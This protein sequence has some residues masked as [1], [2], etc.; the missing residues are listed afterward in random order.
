MS[1]ESDPYPERAWG[2]SIV[3]R[4]AERKT[5][6]PD[7]TDNFDLAIER[8]MRGTI[9][10]D[11]TLDDLPLFK[12]ALR[13]QERVR[14]APQRH[15][16]TSLKRPELQPM[17]TAITKDNGDIDEAAE[18]AYVA[19]IRDETIAVVQRSGPHG[20]AR[21][22]R[23]RRCPQRVEGRRLS[24]QQLKIID[25]RCFVPQ[26]RPRLFI[27][28][29][30]EDLG[31]DPE[32]LFEQALQ[33]LP[34]RNIDP[35]DVLDLDGSRIGEYPPAEVQRLLAMVSPHQRAKLDAALATGRLV[36]GPFSKRERGRKSGERIRRVEIRL[37][38]LASALRVVKGGSSK[39]FLLITRDMTVRMRPI[40]PRE[41]ARLMGVPRQLHPAEQFHRSV[42]AVRRRCLRACGAAPRRSSDRAAARKRCCRRRHGA[43]DGRFSA[44][45][46]NVT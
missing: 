41:A 25:A 31:V 10:V 34:K 38:G 5:L 17:K 44:G 4:F 6:T 9:K 26:S 39:Q 30:D 35:A 42:V 21:P 23:P 40:Q 2:E 19:Q 32:P 37:D 1:D 45:M 14:R 11:P 16:D 12:L 3:R 29:V 27:V 13:D 46:T 43:A 22:G 18:A 36:V 8:V 33:N 24:L 15:T 20:A 7:E 28:G